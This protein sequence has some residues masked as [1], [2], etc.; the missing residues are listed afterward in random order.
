MECCVRE[1]GGNATSVSDSYS[2]EGLRNVGTL[3]VLCQQPSSEG[4]W[5]KGHGASQKEIGART[6]RASR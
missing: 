3:R 6:C 2:S 1:K 4:L 5:H